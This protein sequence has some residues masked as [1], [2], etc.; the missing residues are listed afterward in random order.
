[1]LVR[2]NRIGFGLLSLGL[3]AGAAVGQGGTDA[4][5]PY[6]NPK[7]PVEQRVADLLSRMTLDEKISM[8]SG[9]GWMESTG[10]PRLGIPEIKMADGPMGI[11]IWTGSSA[12]TSVEG[13]VRTFSSTAF[14][15][16]IDV[17]ASWDPS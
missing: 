9:S 11:R 10:V 12:E 8:L 4:S 1:M 6:K 13:A 14:P 2:L 17:A 15:A 16:G 5:A 3:S 7:V